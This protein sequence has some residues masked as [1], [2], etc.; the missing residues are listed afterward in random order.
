MGNL[1][2][3]ISSQILVKFLKFQIWLPNFTDLVFMFQKELGEKII[4][5][6]PSSNYGRISILTN[7][8]LKIKNKFYVSPNSFFPKPKVTSMVIHLK[9]I[10]NSIAIKDI[11][12]L[13]KVTN[14]LFSNKRKMIN[15]NINKLIKKEKS[16]KISF[17][18]LKLRPSEIDPDTYYKITQLYES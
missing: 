3:N 13:E 7:Y 2:Y 6:F 8:R 10:K 14:I 11:S 18:N 16:K 5:K 4:S 17:L 15:K 12:N 1:P 9:P